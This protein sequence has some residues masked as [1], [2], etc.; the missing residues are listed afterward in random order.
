MSQP[1]PALVVAWLLVGSATAAPALA[2]AV[3]PAAQTAVRPGNGVTSPTL[4]SMVDPRYPEA[5]L[6][7][8][9]AAEVHVEAVVAVTGEATD[10]R[11]VKSAGAAFDDAAVDA[12][13]QWRFRPGAR[14]GQ[15]VPVL[16]TIILEFRT[17][18]S[19]EQKLFDSAHREGAAGLINPVK[20]SGRAPQY[21]SDAMRAKIQ[22][23]VEVEIVVLADGRVGAARIVRSLDTQFGLDQAA[24]DAARQWSFQ[25]GTLN[26]ERV[27]VLTR[28]NVGFSLR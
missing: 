10:L 7:A 25:A 23:E 9:R 14:D 12:A 22:G 28:I 26:G 6:A 16:V 5:E 15:S 19:E 20:L 18:P 27:A 17:R 8:G 3:P 1:H 4:L 13:R 2:Q 21:T 24:L 11:V